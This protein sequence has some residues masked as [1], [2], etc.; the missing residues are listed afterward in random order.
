MAVDTYSMADNAAR[1]AECGS[2]MPWSRSRQ[3]ERDSGFPA[4]APVLVESGLCEKC[5]NAERP[6]GV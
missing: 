5:E 1:C 2:F 6:E 4:G 3:V